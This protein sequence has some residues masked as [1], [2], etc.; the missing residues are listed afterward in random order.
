MQRKLIAATAFVLLSLILTACGGPDPL[1]GT[2]W[3]LVSLDDTSPLLGTSITLS[4][5][6]GEINGSGGCNSYSG[7]YQV[8]GDRISFG[9]TVITLQACMEPAG[10]MDQ[11]SAYLA[12]LGGVERY[13]LEDWDLML[14]AQDGKALRFETE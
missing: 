10:V 2:S 5:A 9:E 13:V 12:L 7:L 14:V 11:E 4:F 3:V 1:D 8:Q 6:D